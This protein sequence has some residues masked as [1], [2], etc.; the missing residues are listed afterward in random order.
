[1]RLAVPVLIAALVVS[2]IA[3]PALADDPAP[4]TTPAASATA[5]AT[6]WYGWEQLAA[7]GG[8]ALLALGALAVS[9]SASGDASAFLATASAGG[10]L[11]ASPVIHGMHRHPAKALLAVA[12]RLALP[13]LT[14]AIGYGIGSAAKQSA[15]SASQDSATVNR[16]AQYDPALYAVFAAPVGMVIASILDD[17]FLARDEKAP[18]QA[19]VAPT[20]EPRIGIVAGGA[21]AGVG[22]TF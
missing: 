10:Y 13:A 16:G 4:A 20:V 17:A 6:S 11:V 14:G 15:D 3:P 12:I 18:A 1:M 19:G 7:D 8:A 5:P 9:N 22:G 2:S 21:T